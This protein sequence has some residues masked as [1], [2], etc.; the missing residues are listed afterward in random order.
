MEV[1]VLAVDGMSMKLELTD[2]LKNCMKSTMTAAV[3]VV[4]RPELDVQ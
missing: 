3:Y 1:Y 2:G 4:D